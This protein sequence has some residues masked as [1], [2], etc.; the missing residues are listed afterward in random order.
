MSEADPLTQ[1]ELADHAGVEER[2]PAVRELDAMLPGCG[3]AWK[4]PSITTI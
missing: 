4:K 2:Q 3:S 1:I